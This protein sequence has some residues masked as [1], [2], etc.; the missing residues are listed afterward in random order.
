MVSAPSMRKSKTMNNGIHAD[1]ADLDPEAFR[2][3]QQ[4]S[5]NDTEAMPKR[6]VSEILSLYNMVMTEVAL[7]ILIKLKI[8]VICSTPSVHKSTVPHQQST[9]RFYS[10]ATTTLPE[11]FQ[12]GR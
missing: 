12:F 5:R 1:L 2:N 4:F 11:S 9:I 3:P 8:S 7:P 10:S 6:S